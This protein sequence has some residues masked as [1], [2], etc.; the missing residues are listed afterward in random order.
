MGKASL[1]DPPPLQRSQA[2]SRRE[3]EKMRCMDCAAEHASVKCPSASSLPS[4]APA[5]RVHSDLR[6]TSRV[7]VLLLFLS[8]FRI[9]FSPL[10]SSGLFEVAED[11]SLWPFSRVPRSSSLA[12]EPAS[13]PAFPPRNVVSKESPGQPSAAV[14][15]AFASAAPAPRQFQDSHRGRSSEIQTGDRDGEREGEATLERARGNGDDEDVGTRRR[16]DEHAGGVDSSGRVEE[17]GRRPEGRRGGKRAPGG[18]GGGGSFSRKWGNEEGNTAILD[19]ALHALRWS[20]QAEVHS[21]RHQ[22]PDRSKTTSSAAKEKVRESSKGHARGDLS[23][24]LADSTEGTSVSETS[25]WGKH[26][27]STSLP[28]RGCQV[29]LRYASPSAPPSLS[30]ASLFS[31]PSLPLYPSS[32][33]SPSYPSSSS[34]SS[35]PSSSSS[36]FPPSSSSSPAPSPSSSPSPPPVPPTP[37][38][39]PSSE[40]FEG[41]SGSNDENPPSPSL[42]PFCGEEEDLSACDVVRNG[43][44]YI[45]AASSAL[46]AEVSRHPESVQDGPAPADGPSAGGTGEAPGG[47]DMDAGDAVAA[48]QN[49]RLLKRG[50][51]IVSRGPV[52]VDAGVQLLCPSALFWEE[53]EKLQRQEEIAKKISRENGKRRREASL[54]RRTRRWRKSVLPDNQVRA[55]GL[56]DAPRRPQRSLLG[57]LVSS[58]STTDEEPVGEASAGDDSWSQSNS[59][60]EGAAQSDTR[61]AASV[62]SPDLHASQQASSSPALPSRVFPTPDRIEVC[63]G[64]AIVL[65]PQSLLHCRELLLLSGREVVLQEGSEISAN[66]T[67]LLKADSSTALRTAGT[68]GRASG[69]FPSVSGSLGGHRE[70]MKGR[71]EGAAR[72]ARTGEDAYANSGDEKARQSAQAPRV[73]EGSSGE[74]DAGRV[75]EETPKD[76]G[77]MT[78]QAVEN[79]TAEAQDRQRAAASAHSRPSSEVKN[80]S[81]RGGSH[82]GVGGVLAATCDEEGPEGLYASLSPW[83]PTYGS[84]FLPLHFGSAGQFPSSFPSKEGSRPV[85]KKSHS[86]GASSG[87][88]RSRSLPFAGAEAPRGGGFVLVYA[89][90]RVVLDGG[91]I[92]AS[93]EEGWHA[94]HTESPE[95]FAAERRDRTVTKGGGSVNETDRERERQIEE[96]ERP[97]RGKVDGERGKDSKRSGRP[98]LGSRVSGDRGRGGS[99]DLGSWSDEDMKDGMEVDPQEEVEIEGSRR[100]AGRRQVAMGLSSRLSRW[101]GPLSLWMTPRALRQATRS[102][103]ERVRGGG[104]GREGA[105]EREGREGGEKRQNWRKRDR[106]DENVSSIPLQATAGS[107]GTVLLISRDLRLSRPLEGGGKILAQGGGCRTSASLETR[108]QVRRRRESVIASFDPEHMPEQVATRSPESASQARNGGAPGSGE[109]NATETAQYASPAPQ[110]ATQGQ[111]NRELKETKKRGEAVSRGRRRVWRGTHAWR[112]QTKRG[113]ADAKVK[114]QERQMRADAWLR[115]QVWG[116]CAAGG[117]GRMALYIQQ[118]HPLVPLVLATGGCSAMTS[119]VDL[120]PCSCGGGGT[121]FS[122]FHQKL[123]IHNRLETAV[124]SPAA[125]FS[126]S[127]ASASIAPSGG[128]ET[129][130]SSEARPLRANEAE[131][132]ASMFPQIGPLDARDVDKRRALGADTSPPFSNDQDSPLRDTGRDSEGTENGALPSKPPPSQ[133]S[134][135]LSVTEITSIQSTPLPECLFAPA[136]NVEVDSGVALLL[137]SSMCPGADPLEDKSARQGQRRSRRREEQKDGAIERARE[138]E[139]A[140][141]VGGDA[142]DGEQRLRCNSGVREREE[143]TRRLFVDTAKS[144]ENSVRTNGSEDDRSC[145]RTRKE[146]TPSSEGSNGETAVKRERGSEKKQA[147]ESGVQPEVKREGERKMKTL[148]PCTEDDNSCDGEGESSKGDGGGSS[149]NAGADSRDQRLSPNGES[150]KDTGGET[151]ESACVEKA[152]K[153][154]LDCYSGFDPSVSSAKR[155]FSN[156]SDG[157]EEQSQTAGA[158]ES[159]A[160]G[161]EERSGC[162]KEG[163]EDPARQTHC[164]EQE[165]EEEDNKERGDEGEGSSMPTRVRSGCVVVVGTLLLHG[166]VKGASLRVLEPLHLHAASGSIRLR[167]Q[168]VIAFSFPEFTSSL[169]TGDAD[170]S[171]IHPS[172]SSPPSS[173]APS[174]SSGSSSASLRSAAFLPGARFPILSASG[175]V[176]IDANASVIFPSSLLQAAAPSR[177]SPFSSSGSSVFSSLHA[178]PPGRPP[179]AGAVL[180]GG[181]VLLHGSLRSSPP[182]AASASGSSS[183]ATPPPSRA[184][185]ATFFSLPPSPEPV[186]VYGQEGLT[187]GEETPRLQDLI[188]FSDGVVKIQ[189]R[190]ESTSEDDDGTRCARLA[191]KQP[192]QPCG[193]LRQ[194]QSAFLA[195]AVATLKQ[196]A[197]VEE[198]REKRGGARLREEKRKREDTKTEQNRGKAREPEHGQHEGDQSPAAELKAEVSNPTVVSVQVGGLAVERNRRTKRQFWRDASRRTSL[199]PEEHSDS[200]THLSGPASFP[201]A[202]ELHRRPRPRGKSAAGAGTSR[203]AWGCATELRDKP[204]A[205]LWMREQKRLG[206]LARHFRHSHLSSREPSSGQIEEES[207]EQM[208][209]DHSD[210]G[211][212]RDEMEHILVPVISAEKLRRDHER[213]GARAGNEEA[214]SKRN[215]TEVKD[216]HMKVQPVEEVRDRGLPEATERSRLEG[217]ARREEGETGGKCRRRDAG[218]E[219]EASEWMREEAQEVGDARGVKE[220]TERRNQDQWPTGRHTEDS[221]R[222]KERGMRGEQEPDG[223]EDNSDGVEEVRNAS[224]TSTNPGEDRR[225]APA[226]TSQREIPTSAPNEDAQTVPRGDEQETGPGTESRD[227]LRGPEGSS[228]REKKEA[229]RDG[230]RSANEASVGGDRAAHLSDGDGLESRGTTHAADFR[231]ESRKAD[232][233]HAVVSN[234]YQVKLFDR[235]Q[236]RRIEAL[237]CGSEPAA[238]AGMETQ[239]TNPRL[240]NEVDALRRGDASRLTPLYSLGL[241]RRLARR[242]AG[243]FSGG[244]RGNE[245]SGG[246][247]KLESVVFWELVESF[248]AA[249]APRFAPPPLIELLLNSSETPRPTVVQDTMP[250]G[251]ASRFSEVSSSSS[252]GVPIAAVGDETS[253]RTHASLNVPPVAMFSPPHDSPGVPLVRPFLPS[254]PSWPSSHVHQIPAVFGNRSQGNSSRV[255][256]PAPQGEATTAAVFATLLTA[257]WLSRADRETLKSEASRKDAGCKAQEEAVGISPQARRKGN[258]TSAGAARN[259]RE[260]HSNKDDEEAEIRGGSSASG[261]IWDD[262]LR[263]PANDREVRHHQTTAKETLGIRETVDMLINGLSFGRPSWYAGGGQLEFK[264]EGLGEGRR[265]DRRDGIE[266]HRDMGEGEESK[267]TDAE[268]RVSQNDEPDGERIGYAGGETAGVVRQRGGE[269]TQR[270]DA[271][272]KG[273]ID[274]L[275]LLMA[276]PL[277]LRK[278]ALPTY[279]PKTRDGGGSLAEHAGTLR[280]V[281]EFPSDASNQQEWPPESLPPYSVS[282]NTESPSAVS[283]SLLSTLKAIEKLKNASAAFWLAPLPSSPQ[284]SLEIPFDIR[285]YGHSGIVVAENSRVSGAA[286][287]LCGGTGAVQ[288]DGRVTARGR[289]CKAG[290]GPGAGRGHRASDVYT[291]ES[292]LTPSPSSGKE[293]KEV[294]GASG[295][296]GFSLSPSHQRSENVTAEPSRGSEGV[297]SS[298]SSPTSLPA[299]SHA[300]CG[301]GGGGHVG[302]GGDGVDP[303]TG[304]P[305]VGTGGV[306]YDVVANAFPLTPGADLGGDNPKAL[307]ASQPTLSRFASPGVSQDSSLSLGEKGMR[308]FSADKAPTREAV[309]QSRD[310]NEQRDPDETRTPSSAVHSTGT[311]SQATSADE[312]RDGEYTSSEPKRVETVGSDVVETNAEVPK[313]ST[314]F[315]TA[316]ATAGMAT[317]GTPV[318]RLSS[319][320]RFLEASLPTTSASGGGGETRRAGAGG[321]LVWLEAFVVEVRGVVDANGEDAEAMQDVPV[322]DS[323]RRALLEEEQQKKIRERQWR[324]DTEAAECA[325]AACRCER[326]RHRSLRR[327]RSLTISES[328][329][330][331]GKKTQRYPF[332]DGGVP[333]EFSTWVCLPAAQQTERER[334]ESVEKESQCTRAPIRGDGDA[335]LIAP[336]GEVAKTRKSQR[337][338]MTEAEDGRPA[339]ER[340]S[341]DKSSQHQTRNRESPLVVAGRHRYSDS[342]VERRRSHEGVVVSAAVPGW[343]T[344]DYALSSRLTGSDEEPPPPSPLAVSLNP[345]SQLSVLESQRHLSWV[346]RLLFLEARDT[347]GIRAIGK[348]IRE[349]RHADIGSRS[350]RHVPVED[351]AAWIR[352]EGRST[353]PSEKAASMV[354]LKGRTAA[355]AVA[356]LPPRLSLHAQDEDHPA[357]SERSAAAAYLA[358]VLVDLS[359]AG[360]GGGAGGSIILRTF[361]L[362]GSGLLSARGGM[363]GRCTGGGGGG[364]VVGIEWLSRANTQSETGPHGRGQPPTSVGDVPRGGRPAPATRNKEAQSVSKGLKCNRSE[365][366]SA[367]VKGILGSGSEDESPHQDAGGNGVGRKERSVKLNESGTSVASAPE[368]ERAKEAGNDEGRSPDPRPSL[369]GTRSKQKGAGSESNYVSLSSIS[370][371]HHLPGFPPA[372]GDIDTRGLAEAG[373][374]L[375]DSGSVLIPSPL[376][377]PLFEPSARDVSEAILGI[378]QRYPSRF[379]PDALLEELETLPLQFAR[380]FTGRIDVSGGASDASQVCELL[381]LPAGLKGFGGQVVAL[382]S[383]NGQSTSCPVG[384]AGWQCVPC[385]AGFFQ[386]PGEGFCRACTNRPEGSSVYVQ[387]AWL[388]VKPDSSSRCPYACLAGFPDVSINPRCL[389]PFLFLLDTLRANTAAF[390]LLLCLLFVTLIAL[391]N[392]ALL[393][394]WQCDPATQFAAFSG[395]DAPLSFGFQPSNPDPSAFGGASAFARKPSPGSSSFRY[396][397]SC[398]FQNEG[399]PS[400]AATQALPGGLGS[401]Y[402]AALAGGANG[403]S[404]SSPAGVSAPPPGLLRKAVQERRSVRMS[405]PYLTMEDLPYH[406][407]RIVLFGSNTPTNPWGLDASPPPYLLPLV[408][409]ERF[410]AFACHA[411]RLCSYSRGFLLLYNV[412]R[413]VYLPAASLLLQAARRRRA[414]RLVSFILSLDNASFPRDVRGL[415][416]SAVST[417]MSTTGT[418]A[419]FWRSIRARELSFGIKVTVSA[420]LDTCCLDVLDFDRNPFDYHLYPHSPMVILPSDTQFLAP[421]GPGAERHA[422]AAARSLAATSMRETHRPDWL[423]SSPS[424]GTSSPDGRRGFLGWCQRVLW[425]RLQ[426]D[427]AIED[428]DADGVAGSRRSASARSK[429]GGA[430]SETARKHGEEPTAGGRQEETRRGSPFIEALQQIVGYEESRILFEFFRRKAAEVEEVDLAEAVHLSAAM[431]APLGDIGSNISSPSQ[432]SSFC[433]TWTDESVTRGDV[434]WRGKMLRGHEAGRRDVLCATCGNRLLVSPCGDSKLEGGKYGTP[435]LEEYPWNC[436]SPVHYPSADSSVGSFASVHSTPED[437]DDRGNIC[438]WRGTLTG[439]ADELLLWRLSSGVASVVELRDGVQKLSAQLLRPH[440]LQASVCIFPVEGFVTRGD[441]RERLA[442]LSSHSPGS[443][444]CGNAA[445]GSKLACGSEKIRFQSSGRSRAIPVVGPTSDP[446]RRPC[447]HPVYSPVFAASRLSHEEAPFERMCTSPIRSQTRQEERKGPATFYAFPALSMS[448]SIEDVLRPATPAAALTASVRT[449]TGQSEL[450]RTSRASSCSGESIGSPASS[451]FAILRAGSPPPSTLAGDSLAGADLE[452]NKSCNRQ[453]VSGFG[454]LARLL[455]FPSPRHPAPPTGLVTDSSVRSE[456]SRLPYPISL[457][458]PASYYMTTPDA[459]STD[460]NSSCPI[461]GTR[462]TTKQNSPS[463]LNHNKSVSSYREFPEVIYTAEYGDTSSALSPMSWLPSWTSASLPNS[464]PLPGMSSSPKQTACSSSVVPVAGYMKARNTSSINRRGI[465]P[466][467]CMRQHVLAL[468]ITELPLSSHFSTGYDDMGRRDE[469]GTPHLLPLAAPLSSAALTSPIDP[470]RLHP[471]NLPASAYVSPSSQGAG[472]GVVSASGSAA[473]GGGPLVNPKPSGSFEIP[474]EQRR[475]VS[476]LSRGNG[477]RYSL[478]TAAGSPSVRKA[479]TQPLLP[480]DSN[481]LE[482]LTVPNEKLVTVRTRDVKVLRPV[483]SSAGRHAEVRIEDRESLTVRERSL[484]HTV[485]PYKRP[486]IE[487][488]RGGRGH[489]GNDELNR[490]GSGPLSDPQASATPSQSYSCFT[491]DA[492]GD[493]ASNGHARVPSDRQTEGSSAEGARLD[494]MRQMRFREATAGGAPVDYKTSVSRQLLPGAVAGLQANS[495]DSH[496]LAQTATHSFEARGFAYEALPGRNTLG[497]AAT[498]RAVA[499]A[500][501]GDLRRRL[502]QRLGG[503]PGSPE[504][505]PSSAACAGSTLKPGSEHTTPCSARDPTCRHR[506]GQRL[507]ESWREFLNGAKGTATVHGSRDEKRDQGVDGECGVAG[508]SFVPYVEAVGEEASTALGRWSEKIA[509]AFRWRLLKNVPVAI[510]SRL[511]FAAFA[512]LFLLHTVIL[513]VQYYTMYHAAHPAASLLASSTQSPVTPPLLPPHAL[514]PVPFHLSPTLDMA[515]FRSLQSSFPDAVHFYVALLIPP[516]VDLF[517]VVTGLLFLVLSSPSCGELFL[518]SL[519]SSMPR[520]VIGCALRVWEQPQQNFVIMSLLELAFFTVLK[521]AVSAAGSLYLNTV[522]HRRRLAGAGSAVDGVERVVEDVV[523]AFGKTAEAKPNQCEPTYGTIDIH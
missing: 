15:V 187:V 391:A 105:S 518:M 394:E 135:I 140:G 12:E 32:S 237:R 328:R 492:R 498:R 308:V 306:S 357:E 474:S 291:S 104:E 362:K 282:A 312:A 277:L 249:G 185:P 428:T 231:P 72:S 290:E 4:V 79:G 452:G 438:R 300:F 194:F 114:E 487:E 256:L 247:S 1:V 22:L 350:S 170:T 31:S 200:L 420:G 407:Q 399:G 299:S 230:N 449:T 401:L 168:S 457:A 321:G 488:R 143:E 86:A 132:R 171:R 430:P 493:G 387:E 161:D 303:R 481:P 222:E 236:V 369:L 223:S 383:L 392:A 157:R 520:H 66:A 89:A 2:F 220:R 432:G 174:L 90:D 153:S 353:S 251:E 472:G 508:V 448:A 468:V 370:T 112:E 454:A 371:R 37:D 315:A 43:T 367:Q 352:P 330:M 152:N 107:G 35:S 173:S 298:S 405:R 273:N 116:D 252:G 471:S 254:L 261:K 378:A 458:S 424:G 219:K 50:L 521:V 450:P 58:T 335:C 267:R 373:A 334:L 234:D 393:F 77:R 221:A 440:G 41:S 61:S 113:E 359:Q 82:G 201:E 25:V 314:E 151:L 106:G 224:K 465:L 81:P 323:V 150:K 166:G 469:V 490:R 329:R 415:P 191:Q 18:E 414:A 455:S 76:E 388:S 27:Q 345:T 38:P 177:L 164:G 193:T 509:I 304:R 67:S 395:V 117:G 141:V 103:R 155:L 294:L 466:V 285:V 176:Q 45:L 210:S 7:T 344:S 243:D 293:R 519:P 255:D 146:S 461:S 301:A 64:D 108:F 16:V 269:T 297:S 309:Q 26:L 316:E 364:G 266:R 441:R 460:E 203:D 6:R 413:A 318:H 456:D 477:P 511:T 232:Q 380:R 75:G 433:R 156:G 368:E 52:V 462:G 9:A 272:D 129:G 419:V 80:A 507:D 229:Q 84:P 59:K 504:N 398:L 376:P 286:I 147:H 512:S 502:L 442:L 51:R 119:R 24:L 239:Q 400:S 11:P 265:D 311:A 500:A 271:S 260:A 110:G 408:V 476:A 186:V 283:A 275:N 510:N 349:A 253:T 386:L 523:A 28:A 295:A 13:A 322:D 338:H 211:A 354:M 78:R 205:L 131:A 182:C 470:P 181:E 421:H 499:A 120:L 97:D 327:E 240:E 183:A 505:V 33:S 248:N 244:Q 227:K 451:T 443:H 342:R 34:S 85:E 74:A 444:G 484:S 53:R 410:A 144:G 402:G 284:G 178:T 62:T 163:N 390:A 167:Q 44:C 93:G 262:R 159:E 385:P 100:R 346:R 148:R 482:S 111:D 195:P 491:E 206:E 60:A 281:H 101:L 63:S 517:T 515:S 496:L 384:R 341:R 375:G 325:E 339:T 235:K 446:A 324:D 250:I 453:C 503:A 48:R 88:D 480:E 46:A 427:Q 379:S 264:I 162:D 355:P 197:E 83:P 276:S 522:E 257:A 99:K 19:I 422:G 94:L 213:F 418:P 434:Y 412:L 479:A 506:R 215:K 184:A 125:A 296:S 71:D 160:G 263:K 21:H 115:S 154:E 180:A 102:P 242:E 137:P 365:M 14:A 337:G 425:M 310:T 149:G 356:P 212:R 238:Q 289:G 317:P 65:S 198:M 133:R 409:P 190:A 118:A 439:E 70:E 214:T 246:P 397:A 208:Q 288:I 305:C 292:Q 126:A 196:I 340:V 366:S 463:H 485:E 494:L 40:G 49:I 351:Q 372:S 270:N 319:S 169:V 5:C 259:T 486:L 501:I 127:A 20:T 136:L 404:P 204:E 47:G 411:N 258:E 417:H 142:T 122:S 358:T 447:A 172:L 363:G 307:A 228:E 109:G 10:A 313:G 241:I 396:S 435:N 445:P 30:P 158:Q 165:R 209:R 382:P 403:S 68:R 245:Q 389:P 429:Q 57:F 121:I 497:A 348:K 278:L 189:S 513:L 336:T 39:S 302:R 73:G 96:R 331:S 320:S 17:E 188:L 29:L 179:P 134:A 467:R 8:L 128:M 326:R 431:N 199:E 423:Y 225:T 437:A 54:R 377:P 218:T 475:S 23:A 333:E 483:R 55:D 216:D 139:T 374:Y 268:E 42:P 332:L 98:G 192:A 130:V 280:D 464:G 123:V 36:S 233:G 406:V 175:S 489:V 95:F 361:A 92:S 207:G 274:A 217:D 279:V 145:G 473:T 516:F 202:G 69:A 138:M 360:Q 87:G 426:D 343:N 478:N 416:R 347:P 381:Q 436:Q 287:L 91:R 124:V 459:G 3:S 56:D 226:W 514:V 495:S